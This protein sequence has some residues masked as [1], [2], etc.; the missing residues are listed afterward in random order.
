MQ[1]QVE[2]ENFR[3]LLLQTTGLPTSVK[4]FLHHVANFPTI[5]RKAFCQNLSSAFLGDFK[6]QVKAGDEGPALKWI[7]PSEN[8]TWHLLLLMVKAGQGQQ[9]ETVSCDQLCS[10]LLDWGDFLTRLRKEAL[11][12]RPSSALDDSSSPSVPGSGC[13][14][15]LA[16]LEA[17]ECTK[18]ELV[19]SKD[20]L[21]SSRICHTLLFYACHVEPRGGKAQRQ[22][23]HHVYHCCKLPGTQ[24]LWFF[25]PKKV[26]ISSFL[27]LKSALQQ[28]AERGD[29]C[30]PLLSSDAV[31]E[32]H[33]VMNMCNFDS[34]YDAGFWEAVKIHSQTKGRVPASV[35]NAAFEVPSCTRSNGSEGPLPQSSKPTEVSTALTGT[36][37]TTKG[38]QQYKKCNGWACSS[39]GHLHADG[40]PV[41]SS[42]QERAS[43][44]KQRWPSEHAEAS[45]SD[46]FLKFYEEEVV[47]NIL[48]PKLYRQHAE[49]HKELKNVKR[50][51]TNMNR[52]IQLLQDLS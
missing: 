41:L 48:L 11:S 30:S 22:V 4:D 1:L 40:Q 49:L 44:E 27:A 32:L 52:A 3:R 9:L 33:Q 42:V 46:L 29:Q 43:V 18:V 34:T 15:E 19:F 24:G 37:T 7:L 16:G 50:E 10:T 12:A 23:R 38:P 21:F 35:L 6:L 8:A 20:N 5:T 25:G 28:D 13:S 47:R 17:T 36:A 26:D 14:S 31:Q 45:A 39:N 2:L 51:L